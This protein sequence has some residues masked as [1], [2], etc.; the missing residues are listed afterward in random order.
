MFKKGI[1]IDLIIEV[2]NLPAEH[3]AQLRQQ[4]EAGN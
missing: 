1:A 2:T 3:I 4:L